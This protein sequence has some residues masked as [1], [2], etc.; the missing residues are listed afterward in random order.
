MIPVYYY[1][2][3]IKVVLWQIFPDTQVFQ[4]QKNSTT[5]CIFS[6]ISLTTLEWLNFSNF[7]GFPEKKW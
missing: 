7:P 1:K 6:A 5:S 4:T 2:H 3:I